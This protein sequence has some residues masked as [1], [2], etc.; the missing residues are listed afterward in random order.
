MR[1]LWYS[2]KSRGLGK[3][4]IWV[5]V[6]V[7]PFSNC[8]HNLS[9]LAFFFFKHR[10]LYRSSG[11][12][13]RNVI[14]GKHFIPGKFST[15]CELLIICTELIKYF[16]VFVCDIIWYSIDPISQMTV[17]AIAQLRWRLILLLFWFFLCVRAFLLLLFLFFLLHCTHCLCDLSSLDQDWTQVLCSENTES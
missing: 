15:K 17:R 6:L 11:I 12:V 1:Q 2:R 3:Q 7:L 9:N 5:Q 4:K 8:D 10:Y 16:N 13:L 14:H